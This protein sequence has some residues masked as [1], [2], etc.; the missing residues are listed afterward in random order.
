MTS[1]YQIRNKFSAVQL[2]RVVASTILLRA[3]I[4]AFEAAQDV[5]QTGE[6][7]VKFATAIGLPH[8]VN[9]SSTFLKPA[10][11]SMQSQAAHRTNQQQQQQQ[12]VAQQAPSSMG[13]QQ[14]TLSASTTSMGLNSA[15]CS[16]GLLSFELSTGF[17]YKPAAS[18]TLATL[19]STLQLTDCLGF[20]L[21]N[22]SCLAINFEMGLCVLLSSSVKHNASQLYSSQ[23]PVFTIY[24]EKLCLFS[25]KYRKKERNKQK[26]L[27]ILS[28]HSWLSFGWRKLK[29]W[30][31]F[32]LV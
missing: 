3:F 24:A 26:M 10:D 14:T 20:C 19:P 25:S 8:Y 22:S 23:F 31:R 17:I 7:I 1:A 16:N 13:T 28:G 4:G 11:L 27:K 9:H 29:S 30:H 2:A 18:E 5:H 21:A 15:E 6:Q 32:D 12:S